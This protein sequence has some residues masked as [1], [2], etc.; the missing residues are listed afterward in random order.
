LD[1][2]LPREACCLSN[3]IVP[4]NSK[5]MKSA[6][7]VSF[8]LSQLM[9]V[10][11]C[12][13]GK[14][15]EYTEAIT[16]SK[17][18]RYWSFDSHSPSKNVESSGGPTS[19]EYPAFGKIN[20]A[21]KMKNG[22]HVTITDPGKDSVFDFDNGDEITVEA[23]VSLDQLRDQ[24]AI[25]TKGRTNNAGFAANNQNWAFRLKSTNGG[26]AGVNFLFRSKGTKDQPADWHRW[27]SNKGFTVG[28]GWHHIAISYRFGDPESIRAYLDGKPVQGKWDMGGPTESPPI[29]DDD[30]V[31]IGSSL[32]GNLS[33]SLFGSVD[34]IALYRSIVPAKVFAG[35]YERIEPEKILPEPKPGALVLTLHPWNNRSKFPINPKTAI[36]Q[37]EQSSLGFVRLP[38]NYDDWGVREDWGEGV[39]VRAVTEIELEPGNYEFLG[40]SRGIARLFVDGEQIL[41]IP[42][43]KRGG[44]AHNQVQ[45]VPTVSREGMRPRF[46][47]DV[48]KFVSFTSSGSKHTVVFDIM[49]GGPGLR[50]EFGE[51][52]LAIARKGEMFRLIGPEP[53][54][55]LTDQ[56][57][58]TFVARTSTELDARDR[59]ARRAADQQKGYWNK[60]HALAVQELTSNNESVTSIDQLIHER[61]KRAR[62]NSGDPDSFFN[63]KVRPILSE[64]CFR[65]HGEKEKGDLNLLDLENLLTGGESGL[66]TIVPGQ[67]IKSHLLTVVSS[68]EEDERMPPKGDGLK[69]GQVAI[70]EKWILQGG[71]PDK[72]PKIVSKRTPL[73]D[74]LTFLRRVWID[75]LGMAPTLEVIRSFQADNSTE[76][77]VK[78]INRVLEKD[79]WA[80]NWVGY[81]QDALA[82][83]PN[84]LKPNLNNTGPFRYWILD[85]LRDNKPMDRFATELIMMRGSTWNGGAAGFKQA[86]QNDVPMAAKAH[87]ISTA[88]LGVEM[89]CARCHDAPY[90]DST[91]QNLFEMAAMLERKSIQVPKTSS[92][93]DSFFEHA[94]KGGRESLIQVSLKIGSTVKPHWPFDELGGKLGAHVLQ[95]PK[96]TREQLAARITFSRRFAEVIANRIWKRLMG[97]GLVETVDDW[98]GQR[99]S[100]RALLAYLADELILSGYDLKAL[101]RLIMMSKA[102]QRGAIDAPDNLAESDRFFEGPYRRRMTAE[103]VV[104]N[105]W[106]VSGKIMD[107]GLLTMDMEGRHRPGFF[108]NFGRPE[109]AWE[110]TT[111]ANER[112][113]PSLA[114]PKMQ[115]II[116]VLLAFG[117]RNSRAEPTSHRIE[118]PNPIQPGVLANGVMGGWLTRLSD[119]SEITRM[120][121]D[122]KSVAQL[123]EDLYLRYL[124]RFPTND[125]KQ[126]FVELL[127]NDFEDR[128]IPKHESL[129]PPPQ[130]RYPYVSWLNH[131]DNEANSIKQEQEED[132]RRGDSPSRFLQTAWREAAEDALWA[133][134]NSPEM[135]LIP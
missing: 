73:V 82:E 116:D 134:L 72:E 130:K 102:Y 65:C 45:P 76:K 79:G 99:L 133:L 103:Q 111:L 48:E 28:D 92:V 55:E 117:W 18:D 81:W 71:K 129:P 5:S 57:W 60:R 68:K 27:T 87:I 89:K 95:D 31:W 77:R 83:N 56:G 69:E 13:A 16:E 122:A 25:L 20:S 123:T 34:E 11:F 17:P 44:G 3:K 59:E 124:T 21:V 98:E 1:K 125:E 58:E 67:P 63:T 101:T 107:L 127:G 97:A 93:P 12:F 40:R 78:M 8:F 46:L 90:H 35:R 54:P 66:P 38:R 64:H 110:F 50:L 84:L 37:W 96:D 41:D 121:R 115:A 52:C 36:G 128:I 9:L 2:T 14:D 6:Q 119:D 100:D 135:I 42:P 118:E 61:I 24:A 51:G 80:D 26:Q 32:G 104:D 131:L 105:A 23:M 94:Q 4:S 10:H 53:G 33:N 132:A 86:S 30:E 88:F 62:K 114:M 109:R 19:P 113:R 75:A 85:A 15:S 39:I 49:V 43:A 22:G 91:Q 29:V 74:D 70:L 120:C 7:V 112:D 47:D 108:M 126:A 106:Q